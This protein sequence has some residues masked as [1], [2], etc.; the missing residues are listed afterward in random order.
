MA[1]IPL[2]LAHCRENPYHLLTHWVREEEPHLR[3]RHEVSRQLDLVARA[4]CDAADDRL[5][6][7]VTRGAARAVAR[8]LR[9]L[10]LDGLDRW[11][12]LHPGASAPSRRYPEERFAEAARILAGDL[13]IP[14]VFTGSASERPMV[15]RIRAAMRTPSH[16]LAGRLTVSTLAAL[17]ARAP[18]LVSN[19]TGPVHI[20]AGVGTPVVVLYALTNPQHQPWRTP[21]RVLSH[22]V[23]CRN[24]HRSVCP[25]SHHH[26]LARIE[27]SVVV[28]AVESLLAE[29]SRSPAPEVRAQGALS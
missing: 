29:T 27:P 4:G 26:C 3:V 6:L 11:V 8:L 12:V 19:N 18:L 25:E 21:S 5:L 13:G 23:P 22:D 10:G 16:S 1:G 15:E 20:A 2:R 24:C 28:S 7:R 9:D 14:V 17:L